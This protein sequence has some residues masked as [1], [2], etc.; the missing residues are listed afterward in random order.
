MLNVQC[1]HL[2]HGLGT[3]SKH[4]WRWL[5]VERP[6]HV[7]LGAGRRFRPWALHAGCQARLDLDLGN[8][9]PRVGNKCVA[10]ARAVVAQALASKLERRSESNVSVPLQ[11]QT[12]RK[13]VFGA[14]AAKTATQLLHTGCNDAAE[15]FVGALTQHRLAA[16]P[17]HAGSGACDAGRQ[18]GRPTAVRVVSSGTRRLG[19]P[20]FG[21]HQPP[22]PQLCH[23]ARS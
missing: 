8:F 13:R 14:G 17:L 22:G 23:Q 11:R 20:R 12:A 10:S 16:C 15:T 21:H 3:P 4:R 7:Q 19:H 1:T 18:P 6:R 5:L 2:V 9:Q